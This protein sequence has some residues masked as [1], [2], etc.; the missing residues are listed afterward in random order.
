MGSRLLKKYIENPLVDEKAIKTRHEQV[1]TLIHEFFK[2]EELQNFLFEVYDL[3]RLSGRVAFGNANARDLLQLKNSLAVLPQIKAVTDE[4][5]FN[6]NIDP[7]SELYQELEHAIYENPPIGIKEGYLI[8]EGFNAELDELKSLRK[9]GKDFI[10]RFEAEE[11]EKTGIKTLKVG[12]N[13]VF[14][15]FIEISKGQIGRASGRARV[16]RLG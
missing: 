1:E 11:R 13:K 8:K 4:M 9:G 10:A 3:E 14:G 5:N 2:K 7:L 16:L 15:Y 12:F 6:L